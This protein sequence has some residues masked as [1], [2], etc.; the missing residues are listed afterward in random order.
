MQSPVFVTWA[1][2]GAVSAVAFL[3]LEAKVVTRVLGARNRRARVFAFFSL[4]WVGFAYATWVA[5]SG[6]HR[7]PRFK[8][9]DLPFIER[10]SWLAAVILLAT[11]YALE[12]TGHAPT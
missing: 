1:I 10:W 9:V 8:T 3:F 2:G 5:V 6:R 12:A 7:H 11:M 4:S